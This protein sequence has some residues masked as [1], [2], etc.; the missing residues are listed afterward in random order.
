M[1]QL[2]NLKFSSDIPYPDI[3]AK[4]KNQIYAKAMLDNM[5]GSNSEMSA[6]SLYFYNH[7]IIRYHENI[8]YI[9]HKIS[10]VEMHHLEIFGKLALQLGGN[11]KLWTVKD[12]S[13]VYWTP[14]Y[15]NYPVEL[16]TILYNA[17][18]SERAAVEKYEQQICCI[19]DTNII[20]N[21][22]RIILDEKI[23]IQLFEAL[24]KEYI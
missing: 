3:C 20:E 17:L 8:S 2:N 18:D 16:E 24:I 6:I 4:N 15:N 22:K 19:K 13:M 21:L 11:P 12:K 10:I 5:G 1:E 9:F 23:H 14:G 7:I